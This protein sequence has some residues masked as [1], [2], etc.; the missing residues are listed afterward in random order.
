LD[1]AKAL[2]LLLSAESAD[3]PPEDSPS[4]LII[5]RYEVVPFEEDG[6]QEEIR[7]LAAWCDSADLA[8]VLLLHGP[9]GSGKTRLLIEWCRRLHHQ[10]WH[11][12]FLDRDADPHGLEPLFAGTVPRFVVVDYGETLPGLTRKLLR[13][14]AR[15]PE[16]GGP[17]TRIVVLSRSA[18]EWW[19][20]LQEEDVPVRGL[21][22]S[23]P[24]PIRLTAVV[25]APEERAAFVDRAA[26]AFAAARAV[27]GPESNELNSY[28]HPRYERVLYLHVAALVQVVASADTMVDADQ[29]PLA[30]ILDHERRAWWRHLEES[31]GVRSVL[32]GTKRSASRAM[33]V[34]T[35][36]RGAE[37]EDEASSLV[38][39]SAPRASTHTHNHLVDLFHRLYPASDGRFVAP[40]EPDLLGE[41][42]VRQA[43]AEDPELLG[44]V[45]D[46]G[47][48]LQAQ[49]ALVAVGRLLLDETLLPGLAEEVLDRVDALRHL[50]VSLR[51]TAATAT[52]RVLREHREAHAEPDETAR[53]RRAELLNNLSVR[54]AGLGRHEDA[55]EAIEQAVAI[56]RKLTTA[57]PDAFLPDLAMSLN[58]LGPRLAALGRREEALNASQQAVDAYRQLAATRPEAFLPDLAMSLNNLSLSLADL[59]RREDALEAIDETVDV[60][61]KLAAARP[62]AFLPDLAMSLNTLSVRLAALGRREDALAAIDEAVDIRRNLA[63]A[64]PDTFLPDLAMS[65]NN[66]SGCLAALGR[67]ED[68]LA[69]IDEAL[70]TLAPFFLRLPQGFAGWMR[71]IVRVYHA[72]CDAAGTS[73]DRTILDPIEETLARLEPGEAGKPLPE[74][75]T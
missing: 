66:R 6:R 71:I 68:A 13:R 47:N 19:R 10:G 12:G 75:D 46:L 18:G 31:I 43:L 21:V 11:V 38:E 3:L 28:T 32:D 62:D 35:L 55:L 34:L 22:A 40:L 25:P 51:D 58:N 30:V 44:R 41:E 45:L 14:L 42:L 36:I 53:T 37:S 26:R 16:T 59:G 9:G 29:S 20:Q 27:P 74:Q 8:S 56:R 70:H 65:L 54:L 24:A 73:L 7:Q 48:E 4:Q 67:R 61:R 15:L 50:P 64:R 5:A 63:A 69:A 1:E 72:R 33:A 2:S 23:S 57:R 52:E 39:L 49:E 60:C 17:R